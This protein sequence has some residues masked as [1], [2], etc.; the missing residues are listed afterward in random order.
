M[1]I[2]NGSR[3]RF[4]PCGKPLSQLHCSNARPC[5]APM[6]VPLM[7]VSLS[8]GPPASGP[9]RVGHMSD[10]SG[11]AYSWRGPMQ[12]EDAGPRSMGWEACGYGQCM[13]TV[14]FQ[15]KHSTSSRHCPSTALFSMG[16]GPAL[17]QGLRMHAFSDGPRVE[18]D[19]R[20]AKPHEIKEPHRQNG[21]NGEHVGG[22]RAQ[23]LQRRRG[24]QHG[25][26]A[27]PR[28]VQLCPGP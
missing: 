16:G 4:G 28:A 13:R 17:A 22:P 7:A 18:L 10:G 26:G 11:T 8:I 5:K 21:S 15:A 27:S 19:R 3:M 20:R 12:R 6:L 9:R 14:Y 2:A 1:A 25:R 23:R 24:C